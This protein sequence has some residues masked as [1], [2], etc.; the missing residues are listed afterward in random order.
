MSIAP[1]HASTTTGAPSSDHFAPLRVVIIDVVEDGRTASAAR[2]DRQAVLG[3]EAGF[4]S[5]PLLSVTGER[6]HRKVMVGRWHLWLDGGGIL[7]E[8]V[9]ER[10][11]D[12]DSG[13]RRICA[14]SAEST[15]VL[16]APFQMRSTS[17]LV[18]RQTLLTALAKEA[19][20]QSRNAVALLRTLRLNLEEA[21]AIS[22]GSSD[23]ESPAKTLPPL[24]NLSI[25]VAH[26]RHEARDAV[27]EGL[28]L[29]RDDS[30]AYQGYRRSRD[31]TLI[32]AHPPA[33]ASTRPWMRTHDAA[34]RQCEAMAELLGEEAQ[35]L[36]Q[37]VQSAG[38]MA[39]I[40]DAESADTLNK[41]A[42]A[43]AVG[44]GLPSL[45]LAYYGADKLF[46]LDLNGTAAVLGVILIPTL[47]AVAASM[48]LSN[49]RGRHATAGMALLVA[50]L[51]LCLIL[52]TIVSKAL[53][54]AGP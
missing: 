33:N 25:S 10:A 37:M 50:C 16:H 34:V 19:A 12:E 47:V 9:I 14:R 35:A 52:P 26:A 53:H 3:R 36:S 44:I 54:L 18:D 39:Q 32:N 40:H 4:R 31:L 27:R 8:A 38:A 22:F 20:E 28:W 17:E 48:L 1:E 42:G 29:W 23:G 7:V 24:I 2:E 11:A 41:V 5:A 13:W 46:A 45:A 30:A 43:A 15:E 49:S 51:L 6:P 21:I